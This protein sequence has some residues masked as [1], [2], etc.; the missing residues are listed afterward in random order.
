MNNEQD[1]GLPWQRLRAPQ[2][3]AIAGIAF[4]VL[5]TTSIVLVRL[6]V[7]ND[8][9][10]GAEWVTTSRRY[11]S[12]ALTLMPFAGIAFLWFI[13]VIRDRL[14]ALEDQFLSTVFFG[15]GLLFLSL[16]FVSMAIAGGIL[17]TAGFGQP[18]DLPRDVIIFGRA[19]L[20]EISNVYAIRMAS[21]FMFSLSTIWWRTRS[22]PAWLPVSTVLTA[23]ALLLVTT[24][25]LWF[26]FLFPA[27]VLLIS[28]Y[29]LTRDI[30]V[31]P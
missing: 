29:I 3:A 6:S 13:G 9:T 4:S 30:R 16:V 31:V 21:V 17:A 26:T 14:G 12:I 24:Q 1:W 22:M 7:P 20:L 8:L 18:E 25:S 10:A 19:V 11:L 23:L 28:L 27:W 15:S 5:F 2:G